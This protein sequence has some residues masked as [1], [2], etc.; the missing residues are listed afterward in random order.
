MDLTS[1]KLPKTCELQ[2]LDA[3]SSLGKGYWDTVKNSH[4]LEREN[5]NER[6][7]NNLYFERKRRQM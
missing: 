6:N 3:A 5:N 2:T 1:K 7:E 4:N